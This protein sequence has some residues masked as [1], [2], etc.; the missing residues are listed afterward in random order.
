MVFNGWMAL[1]AAP[2]LLAVSLVVEKDHW[3]NLQNAPIS[4]WAGLPIR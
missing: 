4:A 1:I 2:L 3:Q